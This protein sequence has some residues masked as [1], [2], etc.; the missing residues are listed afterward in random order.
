M[1]PFV[2]ELYN[3]FAKQPPVHLL[4]RD[5]LGYRVESVQPANSMTALEAGI[6]KSTGMAN[7]DNWEP[8]AQTQFLKDLGYKTVDEYKAALRA[9]AN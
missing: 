7:F 3:E 2:W 4:V 1:M 9:K 8:C 6:L 5:Y